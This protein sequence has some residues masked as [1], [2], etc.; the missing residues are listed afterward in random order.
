MVQ[1]RILDQESCLVGAYCSQAILTVKIGIY[2]CP[3]GACF[4]KL[5]SQRHAC[6]SPKAFHCLFLLDIFCLY[7]KTEKFTGIM[8]RCLKCPHYLSFL[9]E[10]AEEDEKVMDEIDEMRRL[11][12]ELE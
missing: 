3:F 11:S 10:M 12:G 2:H 8:D 6:M 1:I 5:E 7:V 9:R 4:K